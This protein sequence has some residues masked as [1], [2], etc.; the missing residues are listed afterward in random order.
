MKKIFDKNAL[1]EKE[2]ILFLLFIIAVIFMIAY[3]SVGFLGKELGMSVTRYIAIS[4]LLIIY[5][6]NK[7]KIK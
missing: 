2:M 1:N 6:K 7:I 5:I 4:S 3:I